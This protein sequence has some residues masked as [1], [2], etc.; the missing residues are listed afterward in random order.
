M[1]NLQCIL[2]FGE[3]VFAWIRTISF[4]IFWLTPDWGLGLEL[5]HHANLYK[6]IWICHQST[7]TENNYV[8]SWVRVG[9]SEVSWISKTLRNLFYCR[10]G[11]RFWHLRSAVLTLLTCVSSGVCLSTSFIYQSPNPNTTYPSQ[12]NFKICY[13]KFRNCLQ[14]PMR[15]MRMCFSSLYTQLDCCIPSWFPTDTALST[16]SKLILCIP[17]GQVLCQSFL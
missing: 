8:F 17:I 13:K 1:S 5:D 3:L 7:Q 16:P 15:P 10:L 6:F 9:L 12:K 2:H 4:I 11:S 14:W